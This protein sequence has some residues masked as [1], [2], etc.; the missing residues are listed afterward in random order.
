MHPLGELLLRAFVGVAAIPLVLDG[1]AGLRGKELWILKG[2]LWIIFKGR[3]TR[4]AGALLVLVGTVFFYVA[5][6]GF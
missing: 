1:I 4:F 6:R 3:N 5:W 2:D